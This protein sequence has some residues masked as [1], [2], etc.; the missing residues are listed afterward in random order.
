MTIYQPGIHEDLLLLNWYMDLGSGPDFERTF[1]AELASCGAF[2]DSM[3]K[4]LLVYETDEKGIWFAAWFDRIMSA[5]TFG[6]WFRADKRHEKTTLKTVLEALNFGLER[7]PVLLFVT[8]DADVMA[9][10]QKLGFQTMGE[11][12]W[13]FDGESAVVAWLDRARFDVGMARF[14]S[15][16][17]AEVKD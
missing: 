6:L 3:R 7:F 9:Q 14:K 12:P 17:V 11:V 15:L 4:T 16:F 5:G 1:S 10:G 2:L 13:L 8:R